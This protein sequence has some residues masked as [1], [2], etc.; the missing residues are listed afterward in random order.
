MLL[1][2]E[3]N[4]IVNDIFYENVK[5]IEEKMKDI[6]ISSKNQLIEVIKKM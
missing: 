2:G 4:G 1:V 5:M 3:F 6:E